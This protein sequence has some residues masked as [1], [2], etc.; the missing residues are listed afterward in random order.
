MN[1]QENNIKKLKFKYSEYLIGDKKSFSDM[2]NYLDDKFTLEEC[3]ENDQRFNLMNRFLRQNFY[4]SYRNE[5][6]KF[7]AEEL[8]LSY[9]II[10]R[11]EKS[12]AYYSRLNPNMYPL[13]VVFESKTESFDTN[14]PLLSYELGIY[15]G[16]S[17]EDI[18]NNSE[19]L[20]EYLSL[21]EEENMMDLLKEIN[22]DFITPEDK[23]NM[24]ENYII[25]HLNDLNR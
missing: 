2:K 24:L 23:K 25:N 4:H 22:P 12:K 20:G 18:K 17:E 7:S 16:I 21:L 13:Y 8:S 15:Q 1:F 6:Y 5:N 10:K 9:F 3:S 11:D 14:S 19:R